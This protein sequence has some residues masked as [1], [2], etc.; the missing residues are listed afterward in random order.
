MG[1]ERTQ[2]VLRVMRWSA[3]P[4]QT[5]QSW[6]RAVRASA[7]DGLYP[8]RAY[9]NKLTILTESGMDLGCVKTD[10]PFGETRHR[11]FVDDV[12][13]RPHCGEAMM[14]IHEQAQS[15]AL[16]RGLMRQC[17]GRLLMR[18]WS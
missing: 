16:D 2:C 17:A 13:T 15:N 9:V 4:A 10:K 1:R 12:F 5:Q 6:D 3:R 7:R 8:S 14:P 18:F 11:F